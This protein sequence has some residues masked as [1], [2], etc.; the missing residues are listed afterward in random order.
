MS[1]TRPRSTSM[2]AAR[3]VTVLVD[4]HTLTMVSWV[5]ALVC[6]LPVAAPDVDDDLAV[7]VDDDAR[8]DFLAG[9]DVIGQRRKDI[10]ETLVTMTVNVHLPLL[11]F[12]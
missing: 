11:S 4:D 8:A 6:G 9:G 12:C 7:D 3:L 10:A 2:S 5:Q 1:S